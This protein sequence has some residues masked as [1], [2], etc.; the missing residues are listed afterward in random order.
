MY[1]YGN[2][3]SGEGKQSESIVTSFRYSLVTYVESSWIELDKTVNLKRGHSLIGG[4]DQSFNWQSVRNVGSNEPLGKFPDML[5]EA[6]KD[7][8]N[9]HVIVGS[10]K[11]RESYFS[12]FSDERY[13]VAGT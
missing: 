6:R 11:L 8:V 3:I 7:T 5:V 2:K 12:V 1:K 13:H 10:C 9:L 4:D